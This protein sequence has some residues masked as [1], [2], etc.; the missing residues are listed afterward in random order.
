MLFLMKSEEE[1][2]NVL[3]KVQLDSLR[4]IYKVQVFVGGK[5]LSNTLTNLCITLYCILL[6]CAD[7]NCIVLLSIV[8]WI[9]LIIGN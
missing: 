9:Y 6:Y 5:Y 2:R 3:T 4:S 7:L 1:L 8:M